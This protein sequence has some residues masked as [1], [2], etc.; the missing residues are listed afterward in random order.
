[1]PLQSETSLKCHL[2]CLGPHAAIAGYPC[3]WVATAAFA[4]G[5]AEGFQCG[6]GSGRRVTKAFNHLTITADNREQNCDISRVQSWRRGR[7][8]ESVG[9]MR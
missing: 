5:A 4:L 2:H 1:M 6:W 7:A 9:T 8:G 3:E